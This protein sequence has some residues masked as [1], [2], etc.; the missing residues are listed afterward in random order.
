[1]AAP[2][3]EINL[4]KISHNVR[5]L[6]AFYGAKGISICGVTKV[7][8]GNLAIAQLLL[9][10]G[11]TVLG[12]SKVDNLMKMH[13]EG[14]QCQLLLLG[15]PMFSQAEA[16]VKYANISLNT[17]ISVVSE[18]SRC[19]I[20]QNR[21]HK[22]VLMVEYGDLR[23]GIMPDDLDSTIEEV[24]T[25]KGVELIGIGTNMACFGGVQ[26]DDAKMELLSL[27]AIDVEKSHG[28]KLRL[29]SGGNSANYQWFTTVSDVGRINNLRLGES[30]FLGLEP[31]HKKPIPGLFTDAFTLVVEV[32][33][34]KV[35]PYVPYG[36]IGLNAFGEKPQTKEGVPGLRGILGI[37]LQDVAFTGLS[38][39][40]VITLLGGSSDH[41]IINP[42]K[43]GIKVGDE[44]RF[45]LNYPALLSA[46]SSQYISK[47][48]LS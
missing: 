19:A 41:L 29:I 2:R 42:Q 21:V 33:E 34:L 15:P 40:I 12:D 46:M 26:P 5:T 11:I 44:V 6:V 17:E 1:M 45:N 23:E 32:T 35:K 38:P 7:V 39:E 16:I 8:C 24:L 22:V 31:L 30:I 28:I 48:N 47:V 9:D 18:L 4:E 43:S 14:L 10:S 3:L 37:G 20:A 36:T 13:Q 25:L 27:Q